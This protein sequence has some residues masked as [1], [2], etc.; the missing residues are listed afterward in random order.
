MNSDSGPKSQTLPIRIFSMTKKRVK[1][2]MYALSSLIFISV[3][4]LLLLIN[5]IQERGEKKKNNKLVSH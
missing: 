2:D 4:I 3:L 5:V 1:P